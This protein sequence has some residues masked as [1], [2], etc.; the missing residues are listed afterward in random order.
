MYIFSYI[1]NYKEY[2][3]L[4]VYIFVDELISLFFCFLANEYVGVANE[5]L[6]LCPDIAYM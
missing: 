3:F 4:Y 6:I 5:F 2:F 1:N